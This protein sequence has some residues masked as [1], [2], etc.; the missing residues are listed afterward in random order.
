MR[1][2]AK[3]AWGIDQMSIWLGKSASWIAILLIA[4][5]CYE[6]V[7]RYAF[8]APTTWSLE[9]GTFLFAGIWLFSGA[10]TH[11]SNAHVRVDI[12]YSR[13]SPRGKAIIDTV[14]APFVIIF[15]V[16][17]IYQLIDSGIHSMHMNEHSPSQW[18]PPIWVIKM[19]LPVGAGLLSIQAIAII[20]RNACL[21]VTGKELASWE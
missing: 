9:L 20:V 5:I 1:V 11:Q 2:L 7:A 6:V 12:L 18:G 15:C 4:A 17:V 13:L 3:I 19:L 21:A 16:V 10:Y 14:T 8:N